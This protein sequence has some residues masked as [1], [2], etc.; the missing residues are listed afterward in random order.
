MRM[1]HESLLTVMLLGDVQSRRETEQIL[2]EVHLRIKYLYTSF[3][4]CLTLNYLGQVILLYAWW[5]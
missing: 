2:S 4:K 1:S 5:F 3:N